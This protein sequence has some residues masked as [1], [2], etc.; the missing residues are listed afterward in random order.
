MPLYRSRPVYKWTAAP[1]R[2]NDLHGLLTEHGEVMLQDRVGITLAIGPALER[3][4]ERVGRYL[5]RRRV[6]RPDH[7]E[8]TAQA[9]LR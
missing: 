5:R 1:P 9:R 3:V 2:F 6:C 8:R 4:A 7:A